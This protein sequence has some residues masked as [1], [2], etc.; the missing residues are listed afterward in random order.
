MR[1]GDTMEPTTITAWVIVRGRMALA[2]STNEL[3]QAWSQSERRMKKFRNEL[4]DMGYRAVKLQIPAKDFY[5]EATN[6]D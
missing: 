4:Q 2:I 3:E 1:V 6:N 5:G